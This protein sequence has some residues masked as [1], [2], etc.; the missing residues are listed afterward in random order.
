MWH[1]FLTQHEQRSSGLFAEEDAG[2]T[3]MIRFQPPP[4]VDLPTTVPDDVWGRP[5]KVQ[6]DQDEVSTAGMLLDEV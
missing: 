1:R 3:M 4:E 2:P 6:S 5:K